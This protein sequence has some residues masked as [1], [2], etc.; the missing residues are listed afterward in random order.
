[1]PTFEVARD[2]LAAAS[3]DVIAIPA[4][5]VAGDD[6]DHP[7]PALGPEADA[8]ATALEIDLVEELAGLDFDGSVGSVARI[9]TRGRLDA[10]TL[11]V[12]GLGDEADVDA[13]RLRRAG[14][15]IADATSRVA[16][17]ATTLPSAAPGVEPATAAQAVVE[18]ILLGAYRFSTYKSDRDDHALEV[19]ALH[20]ARD[21]DPDGW[22]AGIE[23]G[24]I[25][26]AAALLA[27]DLVNLPSGD[28]RPPAIADRVATELSGT[29]V[30]VR[31]L[32][33][34]ALEEGGY[35]GLLGVGAG[36]TAPP[37][38]VELT[39]APDGASGHVAL[40]GK[41]ITF[42][43]GGLSLKPSASMET[44]K[45][46]MGGAAAVF[47]TVKAAAE[48]GLPVRITGLLAFAENM[49]SGSAIRPGD[50]LHIHGGKTVEVLN[51]DA[52]GRLVLADALVHASEL[53]PDLIVDMATLTGA[54][55]V[56]LGPKIGALMATDDGLAD[57]LLAA[58]QRAGEPFWRLPVASEQ[59]GED[60]KG[61]VGD[62]KNSGWKGAG[63][64]RA[65]LFL[66]EFVGADIPWAHLDIAGVAWSDE[67]SGYLA[68]GA[69]GAPVRTLV[70]WL[71]SR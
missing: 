18:G 70:E 47:A 46:D 2:A 43:S 24:R 14:A 41:G 11:L 17:L 15:A 64:I 44:M 68:K 38:L 9:P 39:Y 37:R 32:D 45:M 36:S 60:L 63:T 16:R 29:G 33:E 65:G 26:A 40:V 23:V 1:M 51:T 52:E 35:G 50:V 49:P 25:T 19:V 57:A 53:S 6:A 21:V 59:Y 3:A 56:A 71:R 13:E 4:T 12:V 28:K 22:Q 5:A 42:D 69:T 54:A 58:G 61:D 66:H 48:L 55:T 8:L 67:R 31:V 27:R 20:A 7:R 10:R 34:E 62:V 30:T